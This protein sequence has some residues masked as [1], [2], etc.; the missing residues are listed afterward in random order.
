AWPPVRAEE[1]PGPRAVPLSDPGAGAL[2]AP[3]DRLRQRRPHARD[4]L[5]LDR[6]GLRRRPLSDPAGYLAQAGGRHRT[7]RSGARAVADPPLQPLCSARLRL[8]AV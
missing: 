2:A 4:L 8:A 1:R 6:A 5:D 3:P 7:R